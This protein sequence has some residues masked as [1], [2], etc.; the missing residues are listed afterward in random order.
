MVPSHEGAEGGS[1][2][3][4][5]L[6]GLVA[7]LFGLVAG[8]SGLVAGFSSSSSAG[9][10]IQSLVPIRKLYGFMILLTRIRRP[11]CTLKFWDMV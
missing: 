2:L 11:R 6:F 4:A 1:G 3:V 7:G 8:L 10:G 5:G 9:A